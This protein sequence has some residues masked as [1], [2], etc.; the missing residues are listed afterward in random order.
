MRS[1]YIPAFAWRDREDSR[2]STLYLGLMYAREIETSRTL[3]AGTK[4][5]DERDVC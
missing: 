1:D 2:S 3:K 4:C 5:L